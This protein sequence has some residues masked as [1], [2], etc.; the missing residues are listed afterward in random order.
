MIT[1]EA[2]R[3]RNWSSAG[4]MASRLSASAVST[5]IPSVAAASLSDANCSTLPGLRGFR[6]TPTR[7]ISGNASFNKPRRLVLSS[8]VSDVNPVMLPSGRARFVTRP[9]STGSA[10]T[11]MMIGMLDVACLAARAAGVPSTTMT[12]TGRRTSSAARSG[13]LSAP[14]AERNSSTSVRPST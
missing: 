14:A 6:S 5:S 2:P 9:V 7:F 11:P 3:S 8:G 12:S 1:A 4:P 10:T 13:N